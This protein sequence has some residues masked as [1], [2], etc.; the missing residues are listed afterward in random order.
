MKNR[1]RL[2]TS[3]TV[4]ALLAAGAVCVVAWADHGKRRGHPSGERKG[5]GACDREQPG[6]SGP[7]D[8]QDGAALGATNAR[9]T[10]RPGAGRD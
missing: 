3:V 10:V 2:L 7:R 6:A 1:K 8:D 5:V 4:L 9:G